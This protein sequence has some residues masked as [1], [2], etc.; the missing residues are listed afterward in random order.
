MLKG[1]YTALVTPFTADGA[2]DEAKTASMIEHMVADGIAGVVVGGSTGEFFTMSIEQ[3][4]QQI[5]L[6]CKLVN[7]R[8]TVIAQAGCLATEDSIDMAKFC[9]KA[10]AD[11]LLVVPSFYETLG[12][13]IV[14][15][16][17]A[18]GKAVDTP[19]MLYNIPGSSSNDITPDVAAQLAKVC[20]ATCMKDST[21]DIHRQYQIAWATNGSVQPVCGADT[22]LIGALAGG[23]EATV[24]GV[25][26]G[27]SK[28]CVALYKY[29]CEKKDLASAQALW[30]KMLPVLHFAENNGYIAVVKAMCKLLGRDQGEPKAPIR[31][32]SEEK[33]AIL[34]G[35]LDDL[36]TVSDLVNKA[37][38]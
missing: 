11:I 1:V 14:D 29:M 34:K 35:Y 19:I 33:V 28:E 3:R 2:I 17:A 32:L 6:I 5:E 23:T 16:Y 25:S 20:N 18:I 9:T 4:K 36:S 27:I 13:D 24:L 22:I 21:G 30:E 12:D 15:H 26:C 7:K 38:E 8:I 31:A 37:F 10:G